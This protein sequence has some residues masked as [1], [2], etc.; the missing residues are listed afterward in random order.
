VPRPRAGVWGEELAFDVT[1]IEANASLEAITPRFVVEQHLQDLFE[2]NSQEMAHDADGATRTADGDLLDHLPGS[3]D[4]E[5]ITANAARSDWISK[6]GRQDREVKGSFYRRAR[7]TSSSA[8]QR[9][10]RFA[11]M[12]RKGADPKATSAT[13]PTAW[14]WTAARRASSWASWSPL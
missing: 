12:K 4:K 5:L 3:N 7:R 11:P 8:R 14:W 6:V 9:P 2:E 1:K 13:R 10:L